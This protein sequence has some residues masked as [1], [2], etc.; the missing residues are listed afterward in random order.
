[1][2]D[3]RLTALDPTLRKIVDDHNET[4]WTICKWLKSLRGDPI[5]W[6][7]DQ[8]VRRTAVN[9]MIR[10]DNDYIEIGSPTPDPEGKMFKVFTIEKTEIKFS[11]GS[12]ER[13]TK[14]LDEFHDGKNVPKGMEHVILDFFYHERKLSAGSHGGTKLKYHLTF[15][16]Y[17]KA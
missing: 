5:Y 8:F 7:R 14:R 15:R 9:L 12:L 17:H 10:H 2:K 1:M 16:I 4:S 13:V 6:D 3:N 11:P